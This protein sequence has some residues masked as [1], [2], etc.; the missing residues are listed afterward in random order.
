LMTHPGFC[1][2][3]LLSAPTRLKYSR[4]QELQA[5]TDP[6]VRNALAERNIQLTRYENLI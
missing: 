1:R 6:V 5:L 3:Q 4:E 2:E